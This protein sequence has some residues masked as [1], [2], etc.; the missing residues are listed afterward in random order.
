MDVRLNILLAGAGL[1]PLD[2]AI[3]AAYAA[4]VMT[5]AVLF[6]KRQNTTGEYFLAGRSMPWWA[7]G[8]SLYASMFSSYSFVGCPGE[9]Y[10]HGIGYALTNFAVML[11]TPVILIV[12]VRTYQRMHFT[13]AYEYL[14]ARFSLP[15]RLLGST[16]FLITKI[17]WMATLLYALSCFICELADISIVTCIIAVG[18]FST[19]YTFAGG[20]R[21]VIWTD[22]IQ[23]FV[24]LVGICAVF[25]VTVKGA[26]GPA[27]AFRIVHDAGKLD[28]SFSFDPTVRVTFWGAIVGF[29]I[30]SL[31]HYGTDQLTLQRLFA[32]RDYR[33][34]RR[35]VLLNSY[36]L[37]PF[38]LLIYAMG[39][40]IFAY[41]RAHP[42]AA[43]IGSPDQVLPFFVGD[44]LPHGLRGL[45]LAALFAAAMS[46]VDSGLNAMSA[47]GITDFYRRLWAPGR[48]E[49]HYTLVAKIMT[50]A[51]GAVIIAM[52][53]C[54]K[55]WGSIIEIGM[56]LM[57]PFFGSLLVLFLMGILTR[58][59]NSLG[60]LVG[61]VAG[62][63]AALLVS[64]YTKVSFFWYSAIG[65][66]VGV[67]V[68]M[69]ASML[70][71]APPREKLAG[72]TVYDT[73]VQEEPQAHHGDPP[74]RA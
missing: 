4:A 62:A 12:F 67:T 9:T 48:Q 18:V 49:E 65:A 63:A 71:P 66:I 35:S 54:V 52:S 7:V 10:F 45:L 32:T 23:F 34:A 8:L 39:V 72:L 28:I 11:A 29:G 56:K 58:R 27:E 40:A 61:G 57:A 43:E 50:L 22:V 60:A 55:D 5:L 38:G 73:E 42:P 37:Y 47:C 21:A 33:Q 20:M 24:F 17:G 3:V 69:A 25:W 14:E 26:G 13:T 46:S 64:K 74:S 19:L 31:A 15:V 59:A 53:I 41:Y 51:F 30:A 6:F 68:G 44:A 2:W 70:A 36:V 16:L 1:A